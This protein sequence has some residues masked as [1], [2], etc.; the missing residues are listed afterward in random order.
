MLLFFGLAVVGVPAVVNSLL[1]LASLLMLAYLLL[2]T[3]LLLEG[4]FFSTCC[5]FSLSL[6][7]YQRPQWPNWPIRWGPLPTPL[8]AFGLAAR[9]STP[10]HC[11]QLAS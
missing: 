11:G 9:S 5:L 1:L 3:F 2:L 4:Q 8:L 6:L 10:M 7:D